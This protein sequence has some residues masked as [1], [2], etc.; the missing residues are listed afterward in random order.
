MLE[1]L[2]GQP[3]PTNLKTVITFESP[4]RAY[5]SLSDY[6]SESWNI[7]TVAD[8]KIDGNNVNIVSVEGNIKNVL[9]CHVLSISDK[10]MVLSSD[11]TV[12][13]DGEVV[14]HEAYGQERY[15]RVTND[16]QDDILGMWEG[17]S[18]GAEGSEFDDGENHRWVYTDSG[19]F[20]YYHKVD[21]K[22]QLSFD[23]YAK[24]FVDGNLL[25]TRWKNAGEGQ[26]EH[27][28]WWEIES[29][30]NG[31]M[32]WKALRM[33]EDGSTYTATFEMIK[34]PYP[35]EE[36]IQ[37]NIVGK[38]INTSINDQDILSNQKFV[39]EF[40]TD[41]KGLVSYSGNPAYG[42]NDA[43]YDKKEFYAGIKDN[44]ILSYINYDENTLLVQRLTI[45]SIS[46][47]KMDCIV[48]I[49]EISN[50][51]AN[52]ATASCTFEKVDKDYSADIVGTWQGV[53]T[54]VAAHGDVANH[55][56]QYKADGTYI[57]TMKNE[58]GEWV[59]SEDEISNYF[60]AGNLLCTRWKNVGEGQK[61]HREW[62]EIESLEDGVMKM[63][64]KRQ[65]EDG[66]ISTD[67]FEM[68]KVE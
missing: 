33:R 55:R 34:I 54:T 15:V 35:T 6:Y 27:R 22:W 37:Q 36:E 41:N 23:E 24:Y 11:W 61:E 68:K 58:Q 8:V 4:T 20:Y 47:N 62:W 65:N 45:T 30:E 53:S 19:T 52:L 66:T 21:G 25:C 50:V 42:D 51:G 39:Y 16:Y 64:A 57:F 32:K 17:C 38:W 60:V 3:C 29:I 2:E 26:E 67:T 43:W 1:E 14:Q 9:D 7:R 46:A 13:E 5:G 18:T 28:E 59:A 12:Y 63:S 44:E 31:V 40:G 48:E 49:G 56:W 10:D